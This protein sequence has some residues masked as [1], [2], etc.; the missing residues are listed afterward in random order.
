MENINYFVTVCTYD[1]FCGQKY[2][3]KG[4]RTILE[5][6]RFY[7]QSRKYDFDKFDHY[8]NTCEPRR[9]SQADVYVL[10][11]QRPHKRSKEEY[12]AIKNSQIYGLL[13]KKQ[14]IIDT[15]LDSISDSK[16][17]FDN[18]NYHSFDDVKD[19]KTPISVP[20][21]DYLFDKGGEFDD[22]PLF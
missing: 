7:K 12:L 3:T 2:E 1:W 21:E 6:W 11:P 4:F 9:S 10:P 5:A 8:Q 18:Y 17:V 19:V 16:L 22:D 15:F 20:E 13:S 14:P